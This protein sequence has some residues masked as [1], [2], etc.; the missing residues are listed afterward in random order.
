MQQ[1][2]NHPIIKTIIILVLVITIT[3]VAGIK[4]IAATIIAEVR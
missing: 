1:P 3:I 2:H 4:T